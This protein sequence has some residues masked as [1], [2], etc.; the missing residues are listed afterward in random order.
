MRF[1]DRRR[2]AIVP[3]T[4][5]LRTLGASA[6]LTGALLL[7]ACTAPGPETPG[8]VAVEPRQPPATVAPSAPGSLIYPDDLTYAG[9]FRLPG[10]EDAD[11]RTW[12]WA[13]GSIT[14]CASGDA[15]GPDDG[16]AGSLF[17]IGHAQRFRVSEIDIPAPV[18]SQNKN[19]EELPVARTLQPFTDAFG[20][21]LAGLEIP[22][23]DIEYV[24]PQPGD[25]GPGML[26][27]VWG[28]WLQY[29]HGP[30]HSARPADLTEP[31]GTGG[32]VFGDLAPR[33]TCEYVFAIPPA[34]A[35]QHAGG[36]RLVSGRYK[37]GGQASQGPTLHAYAPPVG[38]TGPSGG[39]L[40]PITLLAYD[41]V[42]QGGRTLAG[43]EHSDSWIAG[44]WLEAGERSAVIIVGTQGIDE[45]RE[46]WY[47]FADGGDA[48]AEPP[49]TLP[50]N[51]KGWWSDRFEGRILFFDPADLAAVLAGES[52][53]SAPQ[54]Y[55][56]MSID[57]HLFGITHEQQKNRVAGAAYD[58]RGGRLFL[59]EP[60]ADGE[61]P[62]VHVWDVE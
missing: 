51:E 33:G 60:H 62:I 22:V 23:G 24:G 35:Q 13:D 19:A 18:I 14:F 53:S 20:S 46:T 45:N 54:P 59:V 48:Y 5:A 27:L 42:D 39:S 26:H 40:D 38:A 44:S 29:E 55:A 30:T 52:H 17:G 25:A 6:F 21:R 9:A 49:T 10:G 12:A 31:S 57:R 8:P 11:T 15:S 61:M 4:R 41:P 43:Y 36:V 37:D 50:D 47:G 3:A 2:F 56:V 32:W 34:W 28:Q 7:T 58:S 16:Y 1:A